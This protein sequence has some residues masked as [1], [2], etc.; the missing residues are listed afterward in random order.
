M[1]ALFLL[2]ESHDRLRHFLRAIFFEIISFS[3]KTVNLFLKLL[4]VVSTILNRLL[5]LLAASL[6]IFQFVLLLLQ[7]EF[8][9]MIF[10]FILL[11]GI[12]F[13]F[14]LG[15]GLLAGVIEV[16]EVLFGVF[17]MTSDVV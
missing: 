6:Y 8:H 13:L 5:N 2:A 11:D 7:D 3:I 10:Q 17:E 15:G 16:L 9:A 14:L 1:N 4:V 12:L